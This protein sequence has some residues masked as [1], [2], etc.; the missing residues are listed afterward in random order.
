MVKPIQNLEIGSKA[1]MYIISLIW[2]GDILNEK[3]V[4]TKQRKCQQNTNGQIRYKKLSK[5]FLKK[6]SRI[7]T[8]YMRYIY[9]LTP[10]LLT[11]C[12]KYI[13]ELSK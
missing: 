7:Y 12:K 8:L 9:K 2:K 10:E 3:F 13:K 6:F 1:S 4:E 11:N 5:W